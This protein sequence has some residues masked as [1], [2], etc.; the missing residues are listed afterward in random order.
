MPMQAARWKHTEAELQQLQEALARRDADVA[1]LQQQLAQQGAPL[2]MYACMLRLCRDP[3]QHG[4]L[5]PACLVLPSCAA[6][7][8]TALQ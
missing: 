7:V 3:V 2:L 4:L 6:A 8:Q 1:A 5:Q